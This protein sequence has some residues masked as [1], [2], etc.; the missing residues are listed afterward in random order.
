MSSDTYGLRLNGVTSVFNEYGSDSILAPLSFDSELLFCRFDQH[1]AYGGSAFGRALFI[2][3]FA[4][5]FFLLVDGYW[6]WLGLG[7]MFRVLLVRQVHR[8]SPSARSQFGTAAQS[9]RIEA[10]ESFVPVVSEVDDCDARWRDQLREPGTTPA[11]L[12]F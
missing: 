2:V 5:V 11:R 9:P 12:F 10:T 4:L 8:H 1:A 3:A 7:L 6:V